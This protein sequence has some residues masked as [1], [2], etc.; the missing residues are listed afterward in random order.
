MQAQSVLHSSGIDDV[1]AVVEGLLLEEVV[2]VVA[3]FASRGSHLGERPW[4]L[5]DEV[6]SAFFFFLFATLRLVAV[7]CGELLQVPPCCAS[8]SGD[9]TSAR[10]S[11][12]RLGRWC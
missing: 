8:P 1:A 2:A 4:L 12:A 10:G 6:A 3:G 5:F 9:E 7:A 11:I